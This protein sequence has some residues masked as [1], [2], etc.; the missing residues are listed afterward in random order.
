M[1]YLFLPILYF[2]LF[3]F[4]S[5]FIL[6]QI[7][8]FVTRTILKKKTS[9]IQKWSWQCSF[10]LIRLQ[11]YIWAP[12]VPVARKPNINRTH[13]FAPFCYNYQHSLSNTHWEDYSVATGTFVRCVVPSNHFH[14]ASKSPR[15]EEEES[16]PIASLLKQYFPKPAEN[17]HEFPLLLFRSSGLN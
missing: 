3:K 5:F 2:I 8:V 11:L 4:I 17:F 7:Y 6:K 12:G 14:A 10:L 16:L 15:C 1:F 9:P 13:Y